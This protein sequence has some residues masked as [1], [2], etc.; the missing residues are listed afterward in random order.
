MRRRRDSGVYGRAMAESAMAYGE[1]LGTGV[2]DRL[3][4]AVIG[5]GVGDRK[6]V[7]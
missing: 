3:S 4:L 6:S 7:V 1:G 2:G 5:A